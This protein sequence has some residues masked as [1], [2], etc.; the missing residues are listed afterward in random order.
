MIKLK[1]ILTELILNEATNK[2]LVSVDMQPEYHYKQSKMGG[3]GD[4]ILTGFIN[5]LN[6]DDYNRKIVLYNGHDTLGMI[7]ES[8]YKMWL[9]D[10]GVEEEKLDTII[11]YD[12]GYAFFRFCM[13]SGI[14][15]EDI[16]ALVKFMSK[17]NITDSR[18]IKESDLW[19][20]FIKEYDKQE[21][22][23]LL[24]DAGDCINIP[25]LM[26]WLERNVRGGNIELIGG[27]ANECL[28]EVEIALQALGINYTKNSKLIY[29]KHGW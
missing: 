25:D 9:F 14:D 24:E 7:N 16:V 26:D 15:E 2:I 8:D 22:R 19:D 27:G 10:N 12:K 20:E 17:H 13:D 29:E 3:Y 5:A 1:D 6:S 21:L 11:F 4:D 23:E 28:K 18:D